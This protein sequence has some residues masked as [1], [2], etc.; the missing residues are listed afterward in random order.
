L[1]AVEEG[2]TRDLEG[3]FKMLRM[4]AK[5][6]RTVEERKEVVSRRGVLKEEILEEVDPR[7]EVSPMKK[8]LILEARESRRAKRLTAGEE[9]LRDLEEDLEE[10]TRRS[11]E[12]LERMRTEV[13]G[14]REP[15]DDMEAGT[16]PKP[17]PRPK[18][19]SPGSR[20]HSRRSSVAST[21]SSKDA[22]RGFF[23]AQTHL[24]HELSEKLSKSGKPKDT[25][26][27]IKSPESYDGTYT[28]FYNILDKI[29][30]MENYFSQHGTDVIKW[31]GITN[32]SF[33]HRAKTSVTSSP[34]ATAKGTWSDYKEY[35]IKFLLPRQHEDNLRAYRAQ[36]TQLGT[37][38]QYA[39]LWDKLWTAFV[40]AGVTPDEPQWLWDIRRG[41]TKEED[42][43]VIMLAMCTTV[44]E[45]T[46]MI[47]LLD[48]SPARKR[49][50]KD[51]GGRR[52]NNLGF[53]RSDKEDGR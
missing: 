26:E 6:G 15:V 45:M 12:D 51:E 27:K 11:L 24:L 52:N 30:E 3:E 43:R 1:S 9:E 37:L 5:T 39:D 10:A 14:H 25:K 38:T 17:I 50:R 40:R 8:S 19:E 35:L 29:A 33:T 47:R 13:P 49:D 41:L 22:M 4:G 46:G 16:E 44:S 2:D 20:S 23:E 31:I 18:A 53:N 21:G 36:L 34:F 28:L 32:T 48:D 42:R 7:V